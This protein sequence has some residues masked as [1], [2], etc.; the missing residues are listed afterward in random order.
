MVLQDVL[1]SFLVILSGLWVVSPVFGEKESPPLMNGATV[2][3]AE[4]PN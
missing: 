2:V 1:R 3:G 4:L